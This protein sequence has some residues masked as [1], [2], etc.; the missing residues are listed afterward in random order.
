MV[1]QT[2]QETEAKVGREAHDIAE[3]SV[4]WL[5]EIIFSPVV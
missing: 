1:E 4:D 2:L 3:K 5:K